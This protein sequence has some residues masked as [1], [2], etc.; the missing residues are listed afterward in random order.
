[1]PDDPD[2][3][4]KEERFTAGDGR[5][6]CALLVNPEQTAAKVKMID[7]CYGY[8][9]DDPGSDEITLESG[10][11]ETPSG[12]A[13]WLTD[14]VVNQTVQS[15]FMWRRASDSVMEI[16]NAIIDLVRQFLKRRDR[17]A[18]ILK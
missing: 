6:M 7:L 13:D 11:Q 2:S 9:A 3:E 14:E 15:D 16:Q 4:P 1:M 17:A 5:Y 10:P 8:D 18:D 12:I